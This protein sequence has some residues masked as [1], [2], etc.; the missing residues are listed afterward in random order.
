MATD[1]YNRN[2]PIYYKALYYSNNEIYIYSERYQLRFVD[3]NFNLIYFRYDFSF[4]CV[5]NIFRF[6]IFIKHGNNIGNNGS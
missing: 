6:I 2:T 3:N 1:L 5:L 4:F